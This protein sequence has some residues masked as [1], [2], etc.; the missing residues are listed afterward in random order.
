MP[1]AIWNGVTLA[2]SSEGQVVEG[3]IFLPSQSNETIS[4]QA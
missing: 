1:K 2:E 3:I 4:D